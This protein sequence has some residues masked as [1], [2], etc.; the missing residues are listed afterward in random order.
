MEPPLDVLIHCAIVGFKGRE[1]VLL[2]INE[3]GFFEVT[4][5]FGDAPH[6]LLLP[7]ESTVLISQN[8]EESYETSLEIER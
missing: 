5:S 4:T 7:I 8:A 3:L 1:G 2:A 6:R